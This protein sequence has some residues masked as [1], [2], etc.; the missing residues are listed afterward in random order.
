MWQAGDVTASGSIDETV[1][2]HVVT[3]GSGVATVTIQ[4]TQYPDVSRLPAGLAGAT[5]A[6]VTTTGGVVVQATRPSGVN[7]V[8]RA[9]VFVHRREELP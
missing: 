7:C 1:D 2:C 6:L 8:A 3:D 4:G 5:A 9:R